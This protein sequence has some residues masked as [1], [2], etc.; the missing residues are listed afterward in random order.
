MF[1]ILQ[2]WI[3]ISCELLDWVFVMILVAQSYT[4]LALF[5]SNDDYA[6]TLWLE[7]A[8]AK[9]MV[10]C[11]VLHRGCSNAGSFSVTKLLTTSIIY[12]SLRSSIQ[13]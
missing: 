11:S 5:L 1:C 8:T 10:A 12:L 7:H 3:S 4:N 13:V 9:K 2:T 6:L